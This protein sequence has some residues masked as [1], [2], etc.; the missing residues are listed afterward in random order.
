MI[1]IKKAKI[2]V[3][4][5]AV[6]F[7]G[8][9]SG[10]ADVAPASADELAAVNKALMGKLADLEK[11]IA[12]LEGRVSKSEA[13]PAAKVSA[14]PVGDGVMRVA[15]GDINVTGFI[16]TSINWNFQNPEPNAGGNSTLRSFDRDANT[17][18]LNNIQFEFSR[19]APEAGGVGFNSVFMYGSDAQVAESSGFLGGTD[20]FSIQQAYI[21]INLPNI[22]SGLTV[23]A[24]K[25][26]TLQGAEVIENHLN[27]NSSRSLAFNNA[28]P[29]T[30][31][32]VRALYDFLD[33]E[34]T[35]AFGL[36]NGWDNAIDNNDI[37][38]IETR[39]GWNPADTFS[40][41]V[42]FMV[43]SQQDGD[44]ENQR[45]IVDVIV[46]WTPFPE[47]MPELEVMLNYDYGW[48]ED[49]L[50]DTTTSDWHAYALYA[51]YALYDWLTLA[52]R[53][54]QFMDD[55]GVRTGLGR[56]HGLWEMT[57]TADIQLYDNLLTRLEYRHD[58]ANSDTT[59]DANSTSAAA[60][61]LGT[62]NH[63]TTIGA[64]MIYLFG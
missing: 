31:T 58:H 1:N 16:D 35:T 52:A 39:I 11:K 28:I 4:A 20:E 50:D 40:T 56:Y 41:S 60:G 32:G 24:G 8:M 3:L 9:A 23:L 13:R 5:V 53:F 34:I 54:E 36:V 12:K 19:P 37:K 59:F 48:E 27:W 38:D 15:G 63:Q 25:F 26:A 57:Y 61:T 51:K 64:S 49:V 17:F 33:G 29:F 18:D 21:D 22:G 62:S 44:R 55:D 14:A 10:W 30:H 43:G 45:G 2:L 7:T 46:N 47:D 6:M 42:G